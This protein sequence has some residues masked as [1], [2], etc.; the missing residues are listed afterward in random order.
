MSNSV[1]NLS[2]IDGRN[3]FVINDIVKLTGSDIKITNQGDINGDGIDDIVIGAERGDLVQRIISK[4]YITSTKAKTYVIFGTNNSFGTNLKVSQLDGSNGFVINALNYNDYLGASVSSSG[5]INGD[6]FDDLIVGSPYPT[7]RG[8]YAFVQYYLGK[9]Y[10][11]FGKNSSFNASFDL[12]S[13]NGNNGFSIQDKIEGTEFG[14]VVSYAGDINNDGID[15]V[16]INA[17]NNTGDN[18]GY[19]YVLFGSKNGFDTQ[20]N[21]SNLNG[22]NGFTIKTRP[23][24]LNPSNAVS[25]AGDINDDGIDDLIIGVA[26]AFLENQ[27]GEIY[28]VFGSDKGFNSNLDVSTLDGSNGFKIN[29]RDREHYIG[30]SVSNAGDVNGDGIDDLIIGAPGNFYPNFPSGLCYVL[31]GSKNGFGSTFNLANLDGKNGFVI[32][33]AANQ[34]DRSDYFGEI[35]TSAGDINGDGL[36]D[37]IISAQRANPNG[38][39]SGQSYVIFGSKSGFSSRLSVSDLNG[40]NGFI[41]NGAA[42]GNRAGISISGGGDIN[43]DGIDDLVIGSTYSNNVTSLYFDSDFGQANV[44]FG[45]IAPKIDLNGDKKKSINFSNL[46]RD[47]NPVSLVDQVNLTLTDF[48][49]NQGIYT[50]LDPNIALITEATIT[51]TN[52]LDGENEILNVI[53]TG[54]ISANYKNGVLKLT[55]KDTIANYQQVLKSLT[56]QNT[57]ATPNTT[58]RKIEFAIDDGQAHSNISAIATTTLFFKNDDSNFF[59]TKIADDILHIIGNEN[60]VKLKITLQGYNSNSLNELGIFIVDD[61][62]GTINGITPEQAGYTQAALANSITIFSTLPNQPNG[63]N[64]NNISRIVKLDSSSSFRF[65]LIKNQTSDTLQINNYTNSEILFSN[66]NNQIITPLNNN[67]FS[68]NWRDG[69]NPNSSAFDNL[70]VT[71]QPTDEPSPIGTDLQGQTQAEIIDLSNI[72]TLVNAEFIVNREAA[73]NNFVGFYQVTN[74]NGG[75]DT[76]NDGIADILP[77]QAGY[78]QAAVNNRLTGINLTANNQTTATYTGTFTGGAIFAPFIIVNGVPDTILDN[79]PNNN[80]AVYF[81]FIGA[82]LDNIDHLR[83]LGDNIF[84]CE[85]LPGGGDRDY[86]DIIFKINLTAVT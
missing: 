47:N 58:P 19:T 63:F 46:I 23:G 68:V 35:V 49:L 20:F 83:L 36:G 77:G 8:P 43:G 53:T 37:I 76:N 31:F 1:F 62:K 67:T 16:I 79:N 17:P 7:V 18:Y 2:Q 28:V 38:E 57:A 30:Q 71:I 73:Y 60:Q 4:F 48:K 72:N 44:V 27:I 55:G 80:P 82:N 39:N 15:D 26:A 81:P 64:S 10:V 42:R 85:D 78:I 24:Y 52:L 5:D 74:Q 65:Y 61:D 45:N 84:G 70:V 69:S 56:Y 6:G 29:I 21:I 9:S 54:N 41:I 14:K 32:V 51:I 25:T 34:G 40:K 86:N 22:K 33:G 13:L 66:S 50:P 3:G 59:F 75:I 11:V 12:T